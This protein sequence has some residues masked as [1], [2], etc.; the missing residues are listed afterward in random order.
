M[1]QRKQTNAKVAA[2]MRAPSR[3]SPK[4][5]R[6]Q[7]AEALESLKVKHAHAAGID[8]HLKQHWVAVP[9]ELAPPPTKDHPANLPPYVRAFNTNTAD[10]E[11]LADWRH[12]VLVIRWSSCAAI[13]VNGKCSSPTPANTFST[14][15]RR[16][17]R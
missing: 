10:L 1:V 15:R 3:V 12:F 13:F 8:I 4:K 7:K 16:W 2:V 17:N 9:P 11:E 5:S 14:C 6:P